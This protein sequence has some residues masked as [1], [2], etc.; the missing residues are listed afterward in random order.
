MDKHR[1]KLRQQNEEASEGR[2]YSHVFNH[3][4]EY[5]KVMNHVNKDYHMAFKEWLV[6]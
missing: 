3:S 4:R 2:G 5:K 1:K 6:N